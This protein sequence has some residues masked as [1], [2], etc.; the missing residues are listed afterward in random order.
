MITVRALHVDEINETPRRIGSDGN[1]RLPMAGLI[2]AAGLTAGELEEA[3]A[4]RLRSFVLDPEVSVSVT[5]FR[6]GPVS[7]LGAVKN[8]GVYQIQGHKTVAEV[9]S[10]A[11]G[12]DTG[13]GSVVKITREVERGPIA[14]AGAA[15]DASGKFNV[16]EVS[17]TSILKADRPEN[18][19]PIQA[20]DIVSVPRAEMV[21]VIGE[22]QHAGGFPVTDGKAMSMLQAL[23]L[24][25]GLEKTAQP[26]HASLLRPLPGSA[27]RNEIP[28]DLREIMAGRAPDVPMVPGDILLVPNN[29]PKQALLR[30]AEAAIQ[31]GT[32]VVIWRR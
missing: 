27:D 29:T 17:L 25:G 28:V 14:A 13:A 11:G 21:Y 7:V 8:P 30:G 15:V 1:I 19:I 18:N 24:A 2:H 26:K 9:L 6:S 4:A 16:A 5:E 12:P 31:L 3:I 20:H 23:S 10:L 22:V 32:G